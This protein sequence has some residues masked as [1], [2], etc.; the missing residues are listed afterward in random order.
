M[1]MMIIMIMVMI[2]TLII[3]MI[4]IMKRSGGRQRDAH[5]QQGVTHLR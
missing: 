4:M 1:T 5:H 2:M 3:I